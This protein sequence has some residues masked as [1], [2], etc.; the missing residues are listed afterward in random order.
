MDNDCPV[1]VAWATAGYVH[2]ID[3]RG[4]MSHMGRICFHDTCQFS[5]FFLTGS[6]FLPKIL[7][8]SK[9]DAAATNPG[10]GVKGENLR[11]ISF[12][13]CRHP[14]PGLNRPVVKSGDLASVKCTE[15]V[16]CRAA[17]GDGARWSSF[18]KPG[19]GKVC[20]LPKRWPGE[21]TGAAFLPTGSQG[22][23]GRRRRP[24]P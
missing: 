21:G 6:R 10:P 20:R 2:V 4:E 24:E 1:A 9:G 18:G 23:H 13:R 11:R 19:Q 16:P 7:S 22:D 8:R 3:A 5:F 15:S 14:S 17:V 12:R